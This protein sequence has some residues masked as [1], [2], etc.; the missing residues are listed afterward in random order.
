MTKFY[1]VKHLLAYLP[2]LSAFLF[3]S[4]LSAQMS[5]FAGRNTYLG[6]G[7]AA[8][9]AGLFGPYS[10][11]RDASGNV[12]IATS[13]DNRVRKVAAG[14]GIITT[15]AGT[16]IAGYA[17]D[18]GLA[19]AAKFNFNNNYPG[20]AVDKNG[21]IYIGDYGN[22]R[23]RKITVAT[24]IVTT[25]AG[26]GIDG[27]S[28]DGSTALA[29][30]FSGPAGVAV[31][32]AGNV[33]VA[34]NNNSVIRKITIS[35]GKIST[36]AGN[37]NNGGMYSGDGAS[38]LNAGLNFPERLT[39]DAAGN[40]Y[41]SD[42]QDFRIRKVTASTGI[43]TTIAGTGTK[44]YSGDGGAA[45]SAMLGAIIGIAIDA[46]GNI[47]IADQS[48]NRVRKIT[49]STGIISTIAGSTTA[50]YTGNGGAATAAT[51]S[52]P[53]DVLVDGSGNVYIVDNGNNV[54][55]LI[56]TSTGIIST[57]YG[58]G[59]NG[60]TG[61][62][63]QLK[64]QLA[65]QGVALNPNG[66]VLISDGYYYDV[67]AV[68]SA[69]TAY[70][71]AGTPNPDPAFASKGYGGNGSNASF[72]AVLLNAP[73]GVAT[74]ASNNVYI[75]DVNNNVIRVIN[76]N[77]KVISNYA[78]TSTAGFSGDAGAATSAT[79]KLPTGVATDKSGNVYIADAGNNR[80]RMVNASTKIISTI[81]GTGTAGFSGD[82]AAA[83]AAQISN[84]TAVAADGSGNVYFI[85]KG[86]ARVRRIDASTKFISTVLSNSHV[87]T[88]IATDAS[89]NIYVS[90]S[91]A[92]SVLQLAAGT[93]T[94]KTIAGTGVAG[95]SGDGGASVS[96]QLNYPAGLAVDASGNVYVAD[97]KNNV[98]RKFLV[99]GTPKIAN[100]IISTVDSTVTCTGKINLTTLSGT[101]PTGGSGTYTYQWK[102]SLDSI[103]FTPISGA[104]SQNYVVNSAITTTTYYRRFVSSGTLL[105]SGNALVFR[106]RTAPVPAISLGSGSTTICKGNRDTLTATAGYAK[107]V[108]SNAATTQ[109][110]IDTVAGT[111]YVT[112]TDAYGCS[113][114]SASVTT[115]VRALPVPTI[116]LGKGA[117]TICKGVKDTLTASAG[118]VKYLWN[119]AA[120]TASIIDSVSGTFYV[121][122]TDSFGCKG[123]SASTVI[124][125]KAPAPVISLGSGSTSICSG[126]KDT[127]TATAGFVKYLWSTAATTSSIIDSVSGTFYVT[128]TDSFGCKATSPSV[129]ITVNA[130]PA[131]P[132]ITS[133]PATT[134][135]L[136]P[137]T[138]VTLTSSTGTTY[139]WST[140]A[141]TA[142]I[143]VTAAGSY[144][145]TV[146]NASGCSATSAAKTVSYTTAPATPTI[147]SSPATT[148]SLCPG[149]AVTLT[150]STGTTYKWSTSATTASISVT[151]AGS[152]T[153]TVTNAS[154]C[155]ATSA[156]K[157]VSY[158]TAPATPTITAS[159]ATTTNLCPGT[160][161]TLTSSA[162]TTYKWSTAAT[163]ASISVT[164]AGSYTVTITNAAG[165]KATSAA[166]TVSYV[167][168]ATPAS[169]VTSATTATTATLKW[170]KVAC[171]V[172]YYVQYALSTSSTWTTITTTTADT[173]YSLT[174]LTKSTAY[175]W[176]VASICT[177]T[178]SIT[179][180][181]YT[182]AVTFTT[183]AAFTSVS[184]SSVDGLLIDGKSFNAVVYPNPAIS[185]A[186]VTVSGVSGKVLVTVTDLSGRKVWQTE[187]TSTK[188]VTIPVSSFTAGMY[189]VTV[190]DDKHSKVLR[191][192][193]Q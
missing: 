171:A 114:K 46:S 3:C 54:V 14:T 124:T 2:I 72:P 144:T 118:Y 186:N 100:N 190:K 21:N 19:T 179:S 110:I 57:V 49:A 111:F 61:V 11:A 191:L 87:L 99:S 165:C 90:D 27:Y 151:A 55:R 176:Q 127:L 120:T 169:P 150:S 96:A 107:Y 146:T 163:T 156:A 76:Y 119:T 45:T 42:G 130:L 128:V 65:P 15:V 172:K 53:S 122:V 80:I 66:D 185:T 181:A 187:T 129:V 131:T 7:Y 73:V 180:S 39:V 123:T 26:T 64:A 8:S 75:A 113:G 5:T 184:T 193:K 48:N 125:V 101:V 29:A 82:G 16:G 35:T 1:S 91:T 97:V 38:A 135:G 58:D 134:T 121:T 34:D 37:Y 141:T 106:P 30:S 140:A 126:K 159:P 103:T 67:R 52:G 20:I 115:T 108:W 168:C 89:G 18:G 33:Y 77:T 147:T 142:S 69:G 166:K 70:I 32:T 149:T 152:Y 51:L 43:I 145:V 192:L 109:S 47:Y 160:A 153:V 41:I 157:T 44:G 24:G 136:C 40:I 63:T 174:G 68:N 79:L 85:D 102:K 161:V 164:A 92:F 81:A 143:S 117:S 183:P 182:T 189:F 173:T 17:G 148:T 112:V 71:Y 28:G 137:G 167:A 138:A 162:G 12:Y 25:I 88:G 84:P 10:M 36:V 116:S 50:G 9:S 154:G 86:N 93:Y 177:T 23:I 98:I 133:S 13:K 60:F 132:T 4:N 59:T 170:R 178:P 83:T 158:T 22:D 56:T 31:D 188:Q 155:S 175:K 74:D 62:Q 139:K 6:D 104:T 78:G 95:Y 105:D 94:A